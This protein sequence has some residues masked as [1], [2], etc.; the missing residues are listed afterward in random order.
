VDAERL[1]FQQCDDVRRGRGFIEERLRQPLL[2]RRQQT[3]LVQVYEA[4]GGSVGVRSRQP[5]CR[6]S[7]R[8]AGL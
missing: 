7:K 8:L 3:A 4:L 2:H 1:F 5:V 6:Y